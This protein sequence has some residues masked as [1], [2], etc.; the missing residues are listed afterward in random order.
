MP[1]T[2]VPEHVFVS[3]AHQDEMDVKKIVANLEKAGI[4]VWIDQTGLQPGT[5]SWQE[6]IRDAISR[7]FA[8]LLI[9]SPNTIRSRYVPDELSVAE[10]YECPIYPIWIAGTRWIDSIPLGRGL[11]QYIDCRDSQY[12]PGLSQAIEALKKVI[13]G[14]AIKHYPMNTRDKIPQG[15]FSLKFEGEQVIALR[16]V[17]YQTLRSLLDDLYRSYL[18]HRYLPYT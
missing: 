9:A 15:Y 16:P 17:S 3:Y 4:N 8:L 18:V 14:R 6:A 11:T 10:S 5:S 2:P 12:D 13:E 1:Q 7:S